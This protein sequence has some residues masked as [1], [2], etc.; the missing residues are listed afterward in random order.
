MSK[1]KANFTD[2]EKEL[3][4]QEVNKKHTSL[5]GKFSN[6]LSKCRKQS[7][8][9]EVAEKMSQFSGIR[10]DVG[11]IKTKWSN[12]R[13]EAKSCKANYIRELRKTGGG[14]HLVEISQQEEMICSIIGSEAIEG[15]I[16]SENLSI[17]PTKADDNEINNVE[18]SE[19][20]YCIPKASKEIHVHEMKSQCTATDNFP[21][22]KK[23]LSFEE[24]VLTFQNEIL[25]YKKR[26]LEIL[27]RMLQLKEV[28]ICSL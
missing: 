18:E 10:R 15:G 19:K 26:K 1:R 5:F 9:E 13:Q 24:N 11:E 14:E 6:K 25:K 23:E 3:L 8:W 7:L 12:M 16:D 21:V 2:A 27:E 17:E 22:K 28:A 4:I 20:S